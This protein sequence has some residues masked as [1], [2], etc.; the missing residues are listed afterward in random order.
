MPRFAAE[1][2]R[3]IHTR[4][5]GCSVVE[6]R[7]KTRRGGSVVRVKHGDG[8][9]GLHILQHRKSRTELLFC[10]TVN[11]RCP[12]FADDLGRFVLAER[13]LR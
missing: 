5:D 8:K 7:I 2:R 6:E 1:V 13:F 4:N 10:M 3:E 9:D 11:R 12:R